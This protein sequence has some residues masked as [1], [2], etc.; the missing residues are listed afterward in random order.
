M[1]YVS[2]KTLLRQFSFFFKNYKVFLIF[3]KKFC[4]NFAN[5][6]VFPTEKNFQIKTNLSL[7]FDKLYYVSSNRPHTTCF[8]LVTN[9]SGFKIVNL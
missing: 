8:I 2:E 5:F 9:N 4:S 3:W 1:Q 7:I 6:T